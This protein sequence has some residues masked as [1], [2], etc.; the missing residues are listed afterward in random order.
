MRG[1]DQDMPELK[2]LLVPRAAGIPAPSAAL[3]AESQDPIRAELFSPERLEQH[4]ENLAGQPSLNESKRGRPLSP[5]VRDSGRVLLQC[6]RAMGAVI[7]EE[8]ALTPAAEWFLDNFHVVD[9]TLRSIQED[10]PDGFYRELP[11]LA[12]GSLHG[13]PRVLGLAWAFVAH[14]DSHFEPEA[15]R[16]FVRAFQRAQP[17][18]MG[19][20]WAVPSALRLVLVENLRRLAEESSRD[21][22]PAVTPTPWRTSCLASAGNP[23]A[24]WLSNIS[25]PPPGRA[26]SPCSLSSASAS[27]IQCRHRRSVGLV[28]SCRRWKRRPTSWCEPS[29]RARPP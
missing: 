23:P 25:R 26:P 19:E 18:T 17:L 11:K 3:I 8:G 6:Y 24:P 29:I 2:A 15:L 7:R 28:N 1:A 9:E 14:T 12:D 4:A 22:R 20:L 5:R 27:R 21:V 13:Y 10:L 16:R